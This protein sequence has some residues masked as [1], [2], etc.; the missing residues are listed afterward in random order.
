MDRRFRKKM[1][2]YLA[3]RERIALDTFAKLDITSWF[4]F[5]HEHPDFDL[6]ANRAKKMVATLTYSLLKEMERLVSERTEPIQV[7][8]TLCENT[9][10]NAIFV[11]SPNPNGTSFPYSFEGVEW[12]VEEPPEAV[13]LLD[14]AHEIGKA[15]YQDEAVYYIR[16]RA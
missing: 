3:R 7:W 1:E 6:K 8:A 12:G 5:W 2:G 13:G 14:Q 10:D 4:D 11:H 16:Q 9:G 15:K